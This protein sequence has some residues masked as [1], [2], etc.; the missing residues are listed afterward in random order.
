[1]K[2]CI[3]CNTVK[4]YIAFNTRISCKDGWDVRCR[5][6][7]GIKYYKG[8]TYVVARKIFNAQNNNCRKRGQALPS[9]TLKELEQWLIAQS[10]WD[11]LYD[12]WIASG[13][14][15]D[16]APSVDR[17]DN[18][19]SYT[20]SNIQ[21]VTWAENRRLG[22][23]SIYLG[24]DTAQLRPVT[25]Y[26]LDGRKY[27]DFYSVAAAVREVKGRQWGISTVANGVPVKDG[28][29]TLYNPKT[30]KGFIWKWS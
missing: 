24:K 6:C 29:G 15:K 13:Y 2:L 1:M 19:I 3:D 30:Y 23:L 5:E 4:P 27:K 28:R 17:L 25:A 12:A 21:L 7:R 20:L 8:S 14:L 22:R 16:L 18:N 26:H 10:N 9:Y 11:S